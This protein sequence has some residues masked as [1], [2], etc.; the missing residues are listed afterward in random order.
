MSATGMAR[1][2]ALHAMQRPPKSRPPNP[3]E[4]TQSEDDTSIVSDDDSEFVPHWV[5]EMVKIFF[6]HPPIPIPTS[7]SQSMFI[8]QLTSE[9]LGSLKVALKEDGPKA[10]YAQLEEQMLDWIDPFRIKPSGVRTSGASF[11]S[12]T[13]QELKT[14]PTKQGVLTVKPSSTSAPRVAAISYNSMN[15]PTELTEVPCKSHLLGACPSGSAC[16]F[17]HEIARTE[18][19]IC[20]YFL[21]VCMPQATIYKP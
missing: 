10:A 17:S 6:S 2:A 13:L 1:E 12:T 11:T 18:R 20:K 3:A 15:L 16:P 14:I 5:F 21:E 19:S 7:V 9:I 4:V 8:S